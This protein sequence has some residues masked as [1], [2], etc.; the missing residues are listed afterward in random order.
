MI[1]D[2]ELNNLLKAFDAK[3][4]RISNVNQKL[5]DDA[6]RQ[7]SASALGKLRLKRIFELVFTAII[8]LFLGS[9]LHA[10]RENL[11]LAVSAAVLMIFFIVQIIGVVNQLVLISKFDFAGSV[12][13]SQEILSKLQTHIVAFLRLAILQIP[14]YWAYLLIGFKVFFNLDIWEFGNRNWFIANLFFSL[15]L[16]PVSIWL[17]NQV[18]IANINRNWVKTI[19]ESAGKETFD[20]M[21]FLEQLKEFKNSKK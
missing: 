12:T 16:M 10:N 13:E 7:K 14:F 2:Q 21:K 1:K 19:I 15:L 9:F 8:V 20:A 4:S 18:K 11:P 17:C 5:I 3:I 6:Q